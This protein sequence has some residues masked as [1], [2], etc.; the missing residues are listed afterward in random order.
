MSRLPA[1]KNTGRFAGVST[2]KLQLDDGS[3]VTD[4]TGWAFRSEVRTRAGSLVATVAC[5]VVDPATA[6]GALV[7]FDGGAMS[8]WPL[9]PV[10]RDYILTPPSGPEVPTGTEEFNIIRGVTV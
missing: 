3:F 9:G 1:L 6:N 8:G 5:T 2:I 10:V 4:L 7:Q